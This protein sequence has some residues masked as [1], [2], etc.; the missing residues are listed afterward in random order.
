MFVGAINQD[1]R[2]VLA[3]VFQGE[4]GPVHVGCSGNFTVERI[5]AGLGQFVLHGNDVSLY[6]CAVGAHLSGGF[7][8]IGVREEG[9]PWLEEYLQDGL[10]QVAT[11]LLCTE[12]LKYPGRMEPFHRRMESAYRTRWQELH[13]R[14]R[15][16]VEA[17][18]AGVTLESFW[19]G[20]V[21]EFMDRVPQDAA[22]V[23]FPPTYESGYESLYR[24][25]E[26][27]FEWE[28]PE[29]EVFTPERFQTLLDRM[30]S[31]RR[32]VISV[33][34]P[35]DSPL[36]E[37][38]IARVQT[39]ARSHPVWMY[40]NARLSRLTVPRQKVEDVPLERLSGGGE[41]E[42]ALVRLSQGQMNELRSEYLS[43]KIIP[44]GAVLNLGVTWGGK[45]VGAMGFSRGQY[46]DFAAYMMTDFA[47][48][49]T[50]Y[51]R[52]SKLILA[53]ALS[54]E[55]KALLEMVFGMRVE[56]VFTTAFTKKAASMKYRG[57]FEV[58]NRKEGMVNYAAPAGRWSLAEGL[59]WWMERNR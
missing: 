12:Y 10:S 21:V 44:S 58:A 54:H 52:L 35:L 5:L 40:S 16:K 49:P 1:M 3:E 41:G 32:W 50:P 29:Y 46:S 28:A 27:T 34:R 22:V 13:Q 24:A 55:T 25:F 9:L 26:R 18:L 37:L 59:A 15:A 19:P 20:D 8:R 31:K 36:D 23:A 45:L 38:C 39:G 53:A 30:M 42:L 56:M 47:V 2:S 14:T 57:L 4:S 33:D 17:L 7:L 48:R 6:S 51:R 43:T 11:M